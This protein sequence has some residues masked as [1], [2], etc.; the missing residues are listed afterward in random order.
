MGKGMFRRNQLLILGLLIA[1]SRV[2]ARADVTVVVTLSSLSPNPVNISTGEAVFWTDGDGGGP[3]GIY[4]NG[5]GSTETDGSGF[6]F[7]QPGSYGYY[8]DNGNIGTVHVELNTPPLVTISNPTNQASFT[9]PATFFFTAI[10]SDAQGLSDVEFYIGT[11]FIEDVFS[12]PFRTGITN[13]PP[14]NYVLTAIAYDNVFATATNSISITVAA[15]T[16]PALIAK[17]VGNQLV[18]SWTAANAA[19]LSLQS[20]TNL[21][22]GTDWALVPITPSPVGSELVVSNAIV[23]TKQFFR[24]SNH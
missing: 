4:F 21:N 9:A 3:Y 15:A 1:L 5:G 8:D 18:I 13:L 24:L 16:P 17:R 10:A 2:Y 7:S 20:R 14:G 12:E 6:S 11:N 22:S 19:G 23:G